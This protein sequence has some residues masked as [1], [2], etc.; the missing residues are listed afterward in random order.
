MARLNH[1]GIAVLDVE[2]ARSLFR[3]LGLE[4]GATE[5]VPSE[6]VRAHFIP[7]P[8]PGAQIELLEPLEVD[9]DSAVARFLKKRGGGVHHLCVEVDRGT[10]D[11]VSGKLRE[12][13]FRLVYEEA[14]TG[15]HSMRINFVH[16]ATTGGILVELAE[17]GGE[18]ER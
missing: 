8:A 17:P 12:A 1:L 16:P 7:L 6:G 11:A 15:A 9:G 14:R 5:D 18:G 3:I 2:R 13:G 10:L 4:P